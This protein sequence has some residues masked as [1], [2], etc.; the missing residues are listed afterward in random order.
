VD[1]VPFNDK[2][3]DV[4]VAA[5]MRFGRG[6]HP[7]R[8]NFGDCISYAVVSVAGLPLLFT[9]EDFAQIDIARA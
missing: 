4:A 1:I 2:H 9:R 6:H 5:F 3:L 7:A 8:L